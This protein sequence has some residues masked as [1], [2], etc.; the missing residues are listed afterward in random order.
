MEWRDQVR[1]L[2][3]NRDR[4]ALSTFTCARLREPWAVDVEEWIRE[5]VVDAVLSGQAIGFVCTDGEAVVGVATLFPPDSTD[6]L[7]VGF[8]SLLATAISHRRMG[9]ARALKM[10]VMDEAR[11]RGYRFLESRV[12]EDNAAMLAL[13]RTLGADM[14]RLLP[15][16][17]WEFPDHISCVIAL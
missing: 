16:P 8:A 13:N 15:G 10:A 3:P 7:G 11:S 1:L 5:L 4:A 6:T 9:V 17:E 2:D 12:H 14:R